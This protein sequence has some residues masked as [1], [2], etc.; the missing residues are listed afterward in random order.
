MKPRLLDTFCKA[1]GAG[2]GYARAGF[3]VTGVDI[4]PQPRYPYAFTQ[5]DAI[6]YILAHGHEYDVIHASPPCQAYTKSAKEWR[7]KRKAYPDLIKATRSALISTGR[8]YVIENV[9]GAPLLDPTTLCGLMFGLLTIRHRLF[10]TNFTWEAP[11]HPATHPLQVRMGRPV[12]E[13]EYIQVVG[14]FSGASY[15][16]KA[17]GIEWMT[18][19]ELAQAI[20]P[21]YTEWIGKQMVERAFDH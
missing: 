17:M 12:K 5:G 18:I 2:A 8:P 3:E 15:A 10:E 11:E 21:A 7:G 13:G 4:E 6:E 19:A 1:G 16:R 20:P 9:P 14:H